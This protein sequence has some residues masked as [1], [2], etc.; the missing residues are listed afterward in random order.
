[1]IVY[2]LRCGAGHVFEAWFKSSAAFDELAAAGLVTCPH[3]GDVNVVKAPMAP[4]IATHKAEPAPA[5]PMPAPSPGVMARA[6][7]GGKTAVMGPAM[8]EHVQRFL[9]EVRNHVEANFDYVGRGFAEEA[10]KIHYGETTPRPIY[11]EA[12][13]SE[14]EA[15]KDEGIDFLELPL[16]RKPDA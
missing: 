1:M 10:R 14:A 16:P 5:A 15:L 3:C 6:V 8:A 13:P 4:N 2:D 7:A 11:G 12:S 9:A